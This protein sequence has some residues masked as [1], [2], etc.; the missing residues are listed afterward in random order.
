VVSSDFSYACHAREGIGAARR[1]QL[2]SSH[3]LEEGGESEPGS[4][5]SSEGLGPDRTRVRR[6][7]GWMN[8]QHGRP[9]FDRAGTSR[10]SEA[11]L[12]AVDR[13]GK[14]VDSSGVVPQ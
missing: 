13:P 1:G 8:E 14:G 4:A 9:P 7:R 11:T 5:G 2:I 12:A 6:V 3:G 10:R